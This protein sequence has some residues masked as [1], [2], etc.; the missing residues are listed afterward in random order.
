MYNQ[1]NGSIATP[2][3]PY[4]ANPIELCK[5]GNYVDSIKKSS[6]KQLFDKD[7]TTIG[8]LNADGTIY[9]SETNYAT[10][11]YIPIQSNT[12]YYKSYTASPRT[13][14]FNA[15]K[16]PLSTSSYQDL[17]IGGNAGSFTTPA[18][19]VYFR[20]SYPIN[21]TSV[22]NIML[23][24]G[25]TALPYEPYGIGKWYIE[26]NIGKHEIES[27]DIALISTYWYSTHGVYGA[28]ISKD[29][30]NIA[31]TST[32]K[33]SLCNIASKISAIASIGNGKYMFNGNAN[34]VFFFSNTSD[35][36]DKAKAELTGGIIYYNLDTP[37]YIEITDT[38]LLNQLNGI[39]DIEL[40]ENLCYVDWV[41]NVKA[42]M[43]LEYNK[44]VKIDLDLGVQDFSL[45]NG[46]NYTI[47]TQGLKLILKSNDS[48]VYEGIGRYIYTQCRL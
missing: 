5:I 28:G 46:E 32:D 44:D 40:Y 43:S 7:N 39:L 37:T 36:L 27:S 26:K 38:Y 31:K 42:D 13:K 20:F 19:A 8:Y 21:N 9:S 10:S 6:G 4:T 33:Q 35:T 14:F 16:E 12:N 17:S 11:D 45:E 18:N 24:E 25:S 47:D 22:V 1:K 30:L 23:N 15:N 2:Y 34:Y 29:V 3:S 41:G 48:I